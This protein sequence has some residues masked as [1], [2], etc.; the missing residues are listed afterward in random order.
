M[1]KSKKDLS[2]EER[3]ELY[4]L[5]ESGLGIREISRVI[6][7][8]ASTVSRELRRAPRNRVWGRME[9]YEKARLAQDA[10]IK[11]RQCTRTRGWRLKDERTRLFVCE[12]LQKKWS[13]EVISARMRVLYPDRKISHEAIY[14]YV[15]R[16]ERSLLQY[17]ARNGKSQRVNRAFGK[18]SRLKAVAVEKRSIEQRPEQANHRLE[19]GHKESD[20]IVSARG[21]RSC[22]VVLTDR[23][24]R[25]TKLRKIKSREAAVVRQ[26]VFQILHPLIRRSLTVDNGSEHAELAQLEAVFKDDDFQ[27]FYCH[28]YCAWERGTVESINGFIRRFFPKGTNFDHVSDE[29]IQEVEDWI[30]NR[31]MLVLGGY[32]PTEVY[33]RELTLAA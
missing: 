21:G 8:N 33:E 17:L 18:K 6:K 19:V 32:T 7:R 20:L 16:T 24:C 2:R 26:T 25:K 13:P 15:Y 3:Q 30:N 11:R 5:R 14:Q 12:S 28:P 31:P 29:Q 27:V 1:R 4:K 22:L 23:K 9:W 10:A